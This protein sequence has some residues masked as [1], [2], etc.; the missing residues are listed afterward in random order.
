MRPQIIAF[1]LPQ[2]HPTPHNDLWWGPGFTE[3]T[4][5]AKAR[6]LFKGHYQPKIPADL[7][8][9][10]LRLSET[11]EAQAELARKYGI[12]GFCYYHYWFGNGKRELER[13]FNEVLSSGKPDFPFMLCWANESWSAKFWNPDGSKIEKKVLVK[14]SYSDEDS[15]RHFMSL[16]PAFRDPRY[17]KIDGKPAF[18]IYKPLEL[19]DAKAFIERWQELAIK[20]GL[21]GIYFL[22]QLQLDITEE[23]ISK[24]ISDG[25]DAVNTCRLFDIWVSKRTKAQTLSVAFN[26]FIRRIPGI[27][28][29]SDMYPKF[30]NKTDQRENIVP[31]LIP[32]WDHTPRSGKMGTVLTGSSP[33]LFKAH[34]IEVLEGIAHKKNPLV[35]LKSWNEWG[36]GNYVEPDTKFGHGFLEAIRDA[37]VYVENKYQFQKNVEK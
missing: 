25:F 24:L 13:P 37:R 3:W 22:C 29:Y 33:E 23:V 16:L 17:I 28:E 11:R 26:L 4:N 20:N 31:S 2:Y 35:F 8:F 32:N 9:Y 15:D 7:G 34:C 27:R 14:Q 30:F 5:V 10:D 21:K 6:P 1:Y 12:D 18:M 36:E 19:P